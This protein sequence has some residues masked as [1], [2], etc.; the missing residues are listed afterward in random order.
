MSDLVHLIAKRPGAKKYPTL[1][2]PLEQVATA[3]RTAWSE[4]P[5]TTFHPGLVTCEA[6]KLFIAAHGIR[7]VWWKAAA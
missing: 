3:C 1:E 6:C 7:G 2:T 4:R 5:R